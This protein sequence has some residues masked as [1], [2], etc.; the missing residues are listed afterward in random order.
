MELGRAKYPRRMSPIPGTPGSPGHPGH[1]WQER[2]SLQVQVQAPGCRSSSMSPVRGGSV[3]GSAL[4]LSRKRGCSASPSPVDASSLGASP[5]WPMDAGLSEWQDSPESA[6][7]HDPPTDTGQALGSQAQERP[8][9]SMLTP[10]MFSRLAGAP[11]RF[12]QT[13]PLRCHSP[14]R[15]GSI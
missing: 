5:R 7:L 2:P 15:G 11:L 12:T 8:H 14:D 13:L 9:A 3:R 6:R 4:G 10:A 1:W